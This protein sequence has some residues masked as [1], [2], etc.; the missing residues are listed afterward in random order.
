MP[1]LP[2]PLS[3]ETLLAQ[4]ACCGNHCQ[5]CPYQPKWQK[6]NTH[7]LKN[8]SKIK[9]Q[10]MDEM[11]SLQINLK[12]DIQEMAQ[13]LEEVFQ[14]KD[15]QD[16]KESDN[17]SLNE[18]FAVEEI[19]AY[20]SYSVVIECRLHKKLIGI[21]IIGKQHPLTWPD[22]KKAEIFVL[23]VD[24]NYRKKGIG[25]QL[26]EKAEHQAVKMGAKAIVINTHVDLISLHSFYLRSGYQSIGILTEY[27]DNGNAVFFKKKL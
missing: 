3:V 8:Q 25:R 20:L 18:W 22:G 15:S 26:L 2:E 6:D 9:G 23:G 11:F 27:Y 10:L 5:N 21:L 13:F 17:Q 14:E 19:V 16:L 4:G 12:P 24:G 1:R 7:V